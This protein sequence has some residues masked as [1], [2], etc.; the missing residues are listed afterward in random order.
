M[1]PMKSQNNYIRSLIG[2]ATLTSALTGGANAALSL[3]ENAASFNSSTASL[4]TETF[5]SFTTEDSFRTVALD[6]GPFTL[7]MTG[8]TSGGAN[9]IDL[10]AFVTSYSHINN[11]NYAL[12]HPYNGGALFI[13]FDT[14]IKAFGADFAALNDGLVRTSITVNG[15]TVSPSSTTTNVTRFVGVVSDTPFTTV[16]LTSNTGDFYGID[17]VVYGTAVPEPSSSLLICLGGIGMMM[18]RKRRE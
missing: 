1:K 12:V 14:P 4:A 9:Y 3:Y 15:Q 10:A 16:Q 13:T 5:D 11:T 6:V 18:R 17:N 2:V 7:S 8:S